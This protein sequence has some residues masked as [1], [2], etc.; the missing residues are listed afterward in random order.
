[1]QWDW[2]KLE[3]PLTVNSEITGLKKMA[4]FRLGLVEICHVSSFDTEDNYDMYI[5]TKIKVVYA[6]E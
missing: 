1:M 5:L 3:W 6:T 4:Q 2:R